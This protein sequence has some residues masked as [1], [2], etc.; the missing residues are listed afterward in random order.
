MTQAEGRLRRCILWQGDGFYSAARYGELPDA[1]MGYEYVGAKLKDAVAEAKR[2]NLSHPKYVHISTLSRFDQIVVRCSDSPTGGL[3][4][5]GEA[6]ARI[7]G[8]PMPP[9]AKGAEA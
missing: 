3:V 9:S 4:I 1:I 5:S 6:I 8:G 7:T 2:L